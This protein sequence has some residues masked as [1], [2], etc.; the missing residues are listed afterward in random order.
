MLRSSSGPV[1]AL[2]LVGGGARSALWGDLLASVLGLELEVRAGHEAGAA[3]GAARL[4]WLA[5]G[6]ALDEVCQVVGEPTRVHRP[7]TAVADALRERHARFRALYVAL[8]PLFGAA[9][10]GQRGGRSAVG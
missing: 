1:A 8:R 2:S 5:A 6:G 3:L 10:A 4:G 7:D 9:P